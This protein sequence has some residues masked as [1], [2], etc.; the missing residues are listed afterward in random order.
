MYLLFSFLVSR[1][2]IDCPNDGSH[3]LRDLNKLVMNYLIIEGFKD[4]AEK[5][6][7]ESGT[8]PPVNL[9]SIQD[10]MVVRTAIQRGQIEE[11]IERVND[12]NPEVKIL[13]FFLSTVAHTCQEDVCISRNV[14]GGGIALFIIFSYRQFFNLYSHPPFP[15]HISPAPVRSLIPTPSSFST[16]NNNV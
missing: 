9:E 12:L 13:F 2:L 6:S 15:V 5:F 10:R 8:K 3:V 4:A 14:G 16:C 7:Q 1:L 11:A